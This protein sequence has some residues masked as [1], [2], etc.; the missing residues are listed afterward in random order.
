MET[1][2]AII[3]VKGMTCLNCA[4]A[5]P[6][7]ISKVAGVTSANVNFANEK[8]VVEF[9][10]SAVGL[11]NLIA[12]IVDSGY[13]RVTENISLPVLDLDASRAGEL[14]AIVSVSTAS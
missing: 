8:A 12:S 13:Q 5:I 4:A 6:K 10:P 14:E 1:K 2:K 11:E 7:D 9:D 3:P